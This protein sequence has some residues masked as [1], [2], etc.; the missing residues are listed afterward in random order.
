MANQLLQ[1]LQ[2]P[3]LSSRRQ[4]FESI[5][6]GIKYV[7]NHDE[8][9][10]LVRKLESLRLEV[11]L[12]TLSS[13][14]AQGIHSTSQLENLDG[15]VDVPTSAILRMVMECREE[16]R[17]EHQRNTELLL[18]FLEHQSEIAGKRQAES[19]ALQLETLQICRS[20][21]IPG[22][23]KTTC[24]AD[25]M[26]Q[27]PRALLDWLRFA[28]M[29]ARQES[30]SAAHRQTFEWIFSETS[31]DGKA[32][33]K[34]PDWAR[35]GTGIFWIKGKAGSGK[36]TLM[37]MISEAERSCELLSAWAGGK[38]WILSSFYFWHQG[39]DMQRSKLGFLRS[40]LSD[41]LARQPD[42]IPVAFPNWLPK[43][44]AFEPLFDE[45]AAALRRV[46]KQDDTR[47][48]ICVVVDGLDELEGES[49]DM[50]DLVK[51]LYDMT[52][53]SNVKILVSSRPLPPFENAFKGCQSLVLQ[54]LTSDD[55]RSLIT[56]SL[57]THP[58]MAI[59]LEEE[60]FESQRL[61]ERIVE[62]SWGVFL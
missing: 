52:T 34:F 1:L 15:K 51:L 60:T 14:N 46:L 3:G 55:I 42:L 35:S 57:E 50:A 7:W 49:I 10:D 48:K 54:D 17:N 6:A 41:I 19:L 58:H 30:I 61:I 39:S 33:T 62:K 31:Q 16:D 28:R 37:K 26:D 9:E 29:D 11:I 22:Q 45:I 38:D 24:S 8:I 40:V 13:L 56:D 2:T 18:E 25:D 53:S 47:A 5:R 20:L 59:L 27:K 23:Q 32:S 21:S 4:I 43:F 44:A 36:S 12:H